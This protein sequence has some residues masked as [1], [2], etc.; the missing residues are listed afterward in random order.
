MV[1]NAFDSILQELGSSLNIKDLSLDEHN[2][3]LIK[4]PNGLEVYV[5]PAASGEDLLLYTK[6]GEL[7]PGRYREDVLREALKANGFPYPRYG[8]F[9]YSAGNEQL[10]L[11]QFLPMKNL[12]GER[13]ADFLTPLMKRALAWKELLNNNQ[14]PVATTLENIS[15]GGRSRGFFGGLM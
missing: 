12:T 1:A 9:A 3:C 4:F 2:T 7:P 14:I 11:F 13:V 15:A 8:T 10:V 5:E 6:L